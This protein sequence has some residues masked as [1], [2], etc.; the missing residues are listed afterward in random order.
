MARTAE[1]VI[2]AII[3]VAM[4]II[5]DILTTMFC[6]NIYCR[7]N[8]K[9]ESKRAS[10]ET[11]RKVTITSVIIFTCFIMQIN[12]RAIEHIII[13]ASNNYTRDESIAGS[14]AILFYMFGL[15][16]IVLVFIFRIVYTFRNGSLSIFSFSANTIKFL[17][18]SYGINI[19]LVIIVF[20]VRFIDVPFVL[21]IFATIF[22]IH[23][24][25]NYIVCFILFIKRITLMINYKIDNHLSNDH[26]QQ[27]MDTLSEDKENT[28][29][30]NAISENEVIFEID[31]ID[32]LIRYS[33]MVSI[34]FVTTFI[35]ILVAMVAIGVELYDFE[36]VLRQIDS[37]INALCIY[38]LFG[39]GKNLYHKLCKLCDTCLKTWFVKNAVKQRVNDDDD[40]KLTVQET[41]TLLFEQIV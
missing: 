27:E 35:S 4:M 5:G 36:E 30:V 39:F 9:N 2:I 21:T 24:F 28:Q 41:N 14:I 26:N 15:L 22:V 16:G 1:D 31:S 19:A 29:T 33:L 11:N 8:D 34:G 7:G 32:L 6:K 38:L 37:F 17:Y 12:I 20:C 25:I 40:N 3:S 23:Y 18:I 13:I 10:N